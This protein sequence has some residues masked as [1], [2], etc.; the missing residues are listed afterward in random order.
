MIRIDH[1]V[2]IFNDMQMLKVSRHN[3]ILCTTE[4]IIKTLDLLNTTT[5]PIFLIKYLQFQITAQLSTNNN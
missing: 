5:L 3:Q 2:L 4:N 1:S